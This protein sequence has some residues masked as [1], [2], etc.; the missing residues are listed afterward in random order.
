M[1]WDHAK[2]T[3]MASLFV[4]IFLI[5]QDNGFEIAVLQFIL[6][7]GGA[8]FEPDPE[9]CQADIGY[10]FI[11]VNRRLR[12]LGYGIAIVRGVVRIR[13][14]VRSNDLF[15]LMPRSFMPGLVCQMVRKKGVRL[16]FD[17]DGLP[18]DE[19]VEFG[20]LDRH[21]VTL[22]FLRLLEKRIVRH[23]DLVLCRTPE[24]QDVL[25]RRCSAAPLPK[26]FSIVRNGRDPGRFRPRRYEELGS[27][28]HDLSLEPEQPLVTYCG[29]LGSQ[30]CLL[31]MARFFRSL[32]KRRKDIAG[33][34]ITMDREMAGGFLG[35]LG[36]V[37]HRVRVRSLSVREVPI[38]LSASSLGVSFRRPSIS[39]RAV[40]PIKVGEY[41][42]SGVP[43]VLSS[44][45]LVLPAV[46]QSGAV[47]VLSDFSDAEFNSAGEWF[48]DVVLPKREEF[49]RLA[50]QIGVT[51]FQ[52]ASAAKD[53]ERALALLGSF[54]L[55]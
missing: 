55:P 30:Y 33:L 19:R 44:I 14:A 54:G 31:E 40:S 5:L 11:S 37:G 34:L 24:A 52:A 8:A 28:W 17:A 29:S 47:Y 48:V 25:Q 1:T 12:W 9:I 21:P 41:L 13:R 10:S 18:I 50:R 20:T 16:V 42:L 32:M 43:T 49:R 51:E 2:S 39:M 38:Y 7:D 15:A 4:P 23:S 53:Y 46:A 27:I 3:Y 45:P 6:S 35:L 26:R 36:D 22:R